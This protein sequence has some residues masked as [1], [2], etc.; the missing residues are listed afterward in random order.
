M[1]NSHRAPDTTRRSC[2]CRVWCTDANWTIAVNVSSL[3]FFFRIQS[4]VVGNPIQSKADATQTSFV[5]SGVA[6]WISFNNGS[7]LVHKS[8][9][10][11][12][13]IFLRIFCKPF[14]FANGFQ[15]VNT[16]SLQDRHQWTRQQIWLFRWAGRLGV[17]FELYIRQC[18]EVS[19][20]WKCGGLCSK[21]C[22]F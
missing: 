18:Q 7:I 2:L 10:K 1:P 5:V 19:T 22:C 17:L 13:L 14:S 15:S 16:V 3:Q 20:V 21:C 6:V 4:R 8:C 9:D 12:W 11:C